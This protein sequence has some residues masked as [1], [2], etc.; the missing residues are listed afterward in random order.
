MLARD[1]K[2]SAPSTFH[3]IV[4]ANFSASQVIQ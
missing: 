4:C 3:E 2:W 1:G